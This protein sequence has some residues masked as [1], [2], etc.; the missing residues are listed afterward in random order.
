VAAK[1][2][3][4]QRRRCNFSWAKLQFPAE[5]VTSVVYLPLSKD[6]GV[7]GTGVVS[8]AWT[9]TSCSAARSF[10]R[11]AFAALFFINYFFAGIE[12]SQR[13]RLALTQNSWFGGNHEIRSS[14]R[15]GAWHS[16]ERSNDPECALGTCAVVGRRQKALLHLCLLIAAYCLIGRTDCHAVAG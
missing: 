1:Y 16:S 4:R 14:R 6:F 8:T 11:Y 9:R 2:F 3:C 15:L 12:D 5:A 10:I 7:S 13:S